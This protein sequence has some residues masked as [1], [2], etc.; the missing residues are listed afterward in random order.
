VDIA[1][2]IGFIASIA[3][4]SWAMVS[5][6]G[7][8]LSG[9]WDAPSFV[10]V[11]CGG[12]ATTMLSVRMNRFLAFLKIVRNAFFSKIGTHD[13]TILQLVQLAETARREGILSLQSSLGKIENKFVAN[14]LQLVI[15]GTDPETVSKLL[16][17]EL[18]AID[19]RH[20]ESKQVLDLLGKYAPA[21]G[22]IGT[23]VG[24]V[25]MLQNMDDP[26]KIGPG[27][28]VAILTTL[29]GAVMANIVCLPLSDKLNNR[30]AE[31]ALALTIAQSGILG[32]QAGDNPRVL[33]SKLAAFLP[34]KEREKL[35]SAKAA[36]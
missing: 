17:Y 26:K 33:L 36:A 28:A 20:A 8:N 24:L 30:H 9:F 2:V 5:G 21:Y 15:D 27:M 3:L 34:S 14:G 12:V 23:L 11:I 10:L 29:Y 7:E 32:I 1:T 16:E 18:A 19:Q 35:M 4:F 6:A 22:M 31:E 25:C 13:K